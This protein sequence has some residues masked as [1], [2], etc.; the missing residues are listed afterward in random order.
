MSLVASWNEYLLPLVMI[1]MRHFICGHW[2]LRSTKSDDW[3]F[4]TRVPG[5]KLKSKWSGVAA[6][7]YRTLQPD[8]P[9]SPKRKRDLARRK[10]AWRTPPIRPRA[11]E[12][13]NPGMKTGL[14]VIPGRRK[15][16]VCPASKALCK[17]SRN[18]RR[19]SLEN[20]RTDK[21]KPA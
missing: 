7:D 17:Y 20:T 15:T 10:G 14:R 12:P 18:R 1:N 16:P 13:N 11:R 19:D 2:A 8:G 3:R 4:A 6:L 5:L 9:F 21:K